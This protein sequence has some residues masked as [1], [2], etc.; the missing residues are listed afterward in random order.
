MDANAN[1]MGSRWLAPV[2]AA[3]TTV[4]AGLTVFALTL[5]LKKVDVAVP[6]TRDVVLALLGLALVLAAGAIDANGSQEAADTAP[7]PVLAEPTPWHEYEGSFRG[8]VR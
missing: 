6:Q 8:M 1:T 3:L 2:R 4:A 5:V 7:D